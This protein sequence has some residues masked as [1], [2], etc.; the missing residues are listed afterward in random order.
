[1]RVMDHRPVP[2]LGVNRD[3][4]PPGSKDSLPIE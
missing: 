1:M 2:L 4:H 3:G